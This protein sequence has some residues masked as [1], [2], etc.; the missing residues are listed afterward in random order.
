M[1]LRA[2]GLVKVYGKRQVVQQVSLH[3]EPGE[4]VGLLGPNGAGKTTTF[5]MIV[6]FIRP[7]EGEIYLGEERITSLPMYR[8]AQ[9]GIGYLPQEASVFRRMSVEDNLRTVLE[10]RSNLSSKARAERIEQLLSEFGLQHVRHSL[11]QQL[12]G[13][14]RRRTEIARALAIEPRYLL[15]DEPFAGVDPIAVEEIQQIIAKLAE[16]G[17][18]IL[19]TDHNVHETLRITQR[20]YLLYEGKILKEGTAQE[21]AADPQ[22]RR[23]YLGEKFQL[24]P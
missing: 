23:V 2:E 4:I 10:M 6:G 22:V 14:E 19:I 15:L 9:R 20:A 16:K 18:G 24:V 17:I 13:G 12:S 1:R 21:L 3:L 5:Y 7:D 11:G 8:R